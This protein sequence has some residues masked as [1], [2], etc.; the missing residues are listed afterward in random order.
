MKTRTPFKALPK[1]FLHWKGRCSFDMPQ[2][3]F[4][5][6]DQKKIKVVLRN[7]EIKKRRLMDINWTSTFLKTD[8]VGY[9]S[10]PPKRRRKN[11][12]GK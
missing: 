6:K 2:E 1:G 10:P 5:Y 12:S 4:Q 11:V 9:L 3:L 8:I 7:G